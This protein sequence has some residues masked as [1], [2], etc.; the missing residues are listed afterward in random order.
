MEP[1]EALNR[2]IKESHKYILA[3]YANGSY[4]YILLQHTENRD[5]IVTERLPLTSEKGVSSIEEAVFSQPI[6]TRPFEKVFFIADSP[7]FIFIPDAFASTE[8]NPLYFDF[9]F[10]DS[11]GTLISADLPQTGA[12]IL[13]DLNTELSSFVKRTLDRPA[14]L[15]RLAPA[16]EYFFRKSRLGYTSKMYVHWETDH[17]DLFCFNQ[18]GFLLSNSFRIRHI[19]DG[20]YYLLN[21]WKQLGFHAGEDELSLSG[22]HENL[23]QNVIPALRK[24]LSYITLTKFPSHALTGKENLPLPLRLISVYM[25]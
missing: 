9:C 12:K 19:N 4:L 20:I 14:L 3:M 25:R 8:D 6:L 21:A 2:P 10:P 17:I 23:R 13:F 1:I 15:H 11:E 16:C 22:D 5:E 7:R 24:H 18:Q